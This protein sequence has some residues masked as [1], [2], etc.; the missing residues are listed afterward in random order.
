[1][2]TFG[3]RY[4]TDL[5]IDLTN[6]TGQYVKILCKLSKDVKK[7]QDSIDV[8]SWFFTWAFVSSFWQPTQS[9][10]NSAL[11]FLDHLQKGFYFSLP[12]PKLTLKQ[13]QSETGKVTRT[14]T[15]EAMVK[16]IE[17]KPRPW[18]QADLAAS[19][20]GEGEAGL[21]E[22]SSVKGSSLPQNHKTVYEPPLIFRKI[23]CNFLM[24]EQNVYSQNKTSPQ[25]K[26]HKIFL[27]FTFLTIFTS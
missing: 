4:S 8:S 15:M 22:E 10:D 2:Q 16:K 25:A 6:K 1:M 5:S 17:Q 11:I 13:R 20:D 21:S 3:S 7:P 14:R 12:I 27:L 23:C 9:E 26:R 19:W 18:Q 24:Y